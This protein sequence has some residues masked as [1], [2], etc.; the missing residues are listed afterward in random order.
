[1]PPE[2]IESKPVTDYEGSTL[3]LRELLGPTVRALQ[4]LALL[5]ATMIVC[6]NAETVKDT[7]EKTTGSIKC[8]DKCSGEYSSDFQWCKGNLECIND[9]LVTYD[10]CREG[11]D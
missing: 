10:K 6:E 4:V 3:T 11:C 9:A 2:V 1:M 5:V 8:K 7:V